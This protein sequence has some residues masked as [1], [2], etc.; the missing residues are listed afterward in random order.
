MKLLAIDVGGTEIKSAVVDDKYNL[1]DWHSVPTPSTCLEDFLTAIAEIYEP[2]RTQVEGVALSLPGF[3]DTEKGLCNSGGTLVYNAKQYVGPLL[4]EKLGCK[5]LLEND[6]KA[7]AMAELANGALKGCCNAAAFIIGT[8]VGGAIIVDGKLVRGRNF[9]AG[10]LSFVNVNI[11][12]DENFEGGMCNYCATPALLKLYQTKSGNQEEI[13][14]RELF[15]RYHEG[16]RHAAEALNQFT[17]NVAIQTMNLGVILNCEK[18]AIGGGI[19]REP[20]LVEKIREKMND[21]GVNRLIAANGT[22]NY[23]MPE[24]VCC[25]YSA[26]ANLIGAAYSYMLRTGN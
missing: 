11:E 23:M 10:E 9:T 24:V 22:D 7:A 18:V 1:S 15:R 19:S 3:I 8:G 17:T 20:V 21:L 4:E 12:K 16:D 2:Y 5:V 13:N 25:H 14:G 26:D 6:A